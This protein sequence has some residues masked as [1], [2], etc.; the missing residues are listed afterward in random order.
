VGTTATTSAS[1]LRGCTRPLSEAYD[2]ALLD[3]DGV[4]YIAGE[5]ISDAPRHLAEAAAAGMTAAFVTNNASRPPDR[6]PSGCAGWA[7][8]VPTTTW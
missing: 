6:W 5:R 2:T 3:L 4:V 7:W 1:G 8:T